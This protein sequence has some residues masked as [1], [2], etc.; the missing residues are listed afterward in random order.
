MDKRPSAPTISNVISFKNI[1]EPS[2]SVIH[3]LLETKLPAVKWKA[4]IDGEPFTDDELR[5][6]WD[7]FKG[8]LNPGIATGRWSAGGVVVVDLATYPRRR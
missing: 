7:R 1:V 3:L 5:G 6:H 2:F 4:V 8:K